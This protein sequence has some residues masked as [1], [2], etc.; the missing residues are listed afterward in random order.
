M[1]INIPLNEAIDL[2]EIEKNSYTLLVY[3]NPSKEGDPRMIIGDLKEIEGELFDLA[4]SG[5]L[6]AGCD[7]TE[8]IIAQLQTVKSTFDFLSKMFT[9]PPVF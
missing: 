5:L 8:Q 2:V 9:L 1:K 7:D 6:P 3:D 4:S